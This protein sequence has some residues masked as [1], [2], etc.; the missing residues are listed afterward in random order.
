MYNK[1]TLVGRIATDIKMIYSQKGTAIVNF[2]LAVDDYNYSEKQK[3][4]HFFRIV[5][6]GKTAETVATYLSKGKLILIEGKLINRSYQ[7]EGEKKYITEI[8][9]NNVTFLEKVDKN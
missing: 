1:I 7:Q 9:A 8:I 2:S 4:V 3:D 6:F 5:T